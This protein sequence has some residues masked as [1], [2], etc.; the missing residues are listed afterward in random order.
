MQAPP[1]RVAGT[2]E[3]KKYPPAILFVFPLMRVAIKLLCTM[4]GNRRSPP[5]HQIARARSPSIASSPGIARYTLPPPPFSAL[6]NYNPWYVEG[7]FVARC[8]YG[9]RQRNLRGNSK[10]PS[11][12]NSSHP[13]LL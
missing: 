11:F 5:S 13:Y 1:S 2:H 10:K 8:K 6:S 12:P 7:K 3:K 4:L 9:V